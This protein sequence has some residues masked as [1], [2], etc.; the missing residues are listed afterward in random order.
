MFHSVRVNNCTVQ[1]EP[2]CCCFLILRVKHVLSLQE[3][4][5]HRRAAQ[6]CEHT[7]I[8]FISSTISRL[9]LSSLS[10]S[11]LVLRKKLFLHSLPSQQ[12]RR[13]AKE[14]SVTFSTISQ[15]TMQQSE[16]IAQSQPTTGGSCAIRN[17]YE[18]CEENM[19]KLSP[20]RSEWIRL[21]SENTQK[22]AKI[23]IKQ[24]S[25]KSHC[26]VQHI[27]L[28]TRRHSS[29]AASVGKYVWKCQ[30]SYLV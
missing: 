27:V 9:C 16:R 18:R 11:S 2:V 24:I 25:S 20:N 14:Q 8:T 5:S 30:T 21:R 1:K 22:E 12:D 29:S 4:A 13:I 17:H 23:S 26:A 28:Q 15:D 19:T 7:L 3:M 6:T 10:G